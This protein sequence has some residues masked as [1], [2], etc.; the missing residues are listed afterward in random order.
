MAGDRQPPPLSDIASDY[1]DYNSLVC[2]SITLELWSLVSRHA[3]RSYESRALGWF[4]WK[5]EL[6]FMA[7]LAIKELRKDEEE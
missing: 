3:T 6:E 1:I 5:K 2:F 7:S 4:K